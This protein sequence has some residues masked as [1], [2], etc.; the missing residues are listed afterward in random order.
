MQARIIQGLCDTKKSNPVLLLLSPFFYDW[1]IRDPPDASFLK[2]LHTQQKS[3]WDT[4]LL[5]PQYF[6]TLTVK[7][8]GAEGNLEAY[9]FSKNCQHQ[10]LKLD[11][12]SDNFKTWGQNFEWATL[13][14]QMRWC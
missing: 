8:L 4:S 13:Q 14:K 7:V 3:A 6:F 10:Q 12:E 5:T 11:S 1:K 2:D 9:S